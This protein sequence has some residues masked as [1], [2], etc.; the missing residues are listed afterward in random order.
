MRNDS[1]RPLRIYTG[2]ELQVLEILCRMKSETQC[3]VKKYR[4]QGSVKITET[5][6]VRILKRFDNYIEID[7]HN[8]MKLGISAMNIN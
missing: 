1:A 8:K 3:Y 5:M 2:K 4:E 7:L 6:K